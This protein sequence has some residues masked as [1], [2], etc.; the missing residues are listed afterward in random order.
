[1]QTLRAALRE[2]SSDE[3]RRQAAAGL[4]HL[5]DVSAVP[6][7]LADLESGGSDHVLAQ[8]VMGLGTIADVRAVP[9]LMHIVHDTSVTDLVRAIACAGLGLLGDLEPFASLSRLGADSNYL[10]PTNALYEALSLL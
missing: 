2:R 3:L 8:V 1:M 4:G 7:L 9:G 10:T 6:L 5:G